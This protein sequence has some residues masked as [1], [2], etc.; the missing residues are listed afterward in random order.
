MSQSYGLMQEATGCVQLVPHHTEL[1][2]PKP[3]EL[4][5]SFLKYAQSERRS[6]LKMLIGLYY[7]MFPDTM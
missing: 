5:W 6:A 4:D 2:T 7:V 1:R 3:I